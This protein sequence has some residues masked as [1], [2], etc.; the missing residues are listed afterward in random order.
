MTR[1]DY[2]DRIARL[3]EINHALREGHL[4]AEEHARLEALSIALTEQ[5]LTPWFPVTYQGRLAMLALTATGLVGLTLGPF[6]LVAAW[7]IA[8]L[9]SPRLAGGSLYPGGSVRRRHRD[10]RDA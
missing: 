5:L 4:T 10:P 2:A 3:A 1:K 9:L 7:P 8:L 6:I